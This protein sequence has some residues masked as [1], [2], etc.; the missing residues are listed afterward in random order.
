ME[1]QSFSKPTEFQVGILYSITV[2]LLVYVGS[3]VQRWN[4]N[5][6]ILITEFIL[7]LLPVLIFLFSFRFDVKN[8]LR[9]NKPT[10]WNMFLI[11]WIMLFSIPVS[12]G[13]NVLNLWIIKSVFGKIEVPAVPVGENMIGLLVSVFVIAVSAGICEEVLFRGVIMRGFERRGAVKAIVI[14]GI[15]FGFM[16][17]DFQKLIGTMLLGILIG[18]LVYR[19]NSLYCGIFA[20]FL[21]NA[22][23]TVG[24]Y[25]AARASEYLEKSGMADAK[26]PKGGDVFEIYA[27]M[28][29]IQLI[30]V[31]IAGAIMFAFSATC[32]SFLIY[33]FIK[34]SPKKEGATDIGMDRG[35]FS[36]L[37]YA[38]LLPG[39]LIVMLLYVVQGLLMKGLVA[40]ETIKQ[41]YNF[42]GLY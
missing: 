20:H 19:G 7:I 27:A 42:I 16:H 34:T 31:I 12:S 25:Y 6:G 13:I 1:K 29:Q 17:L 37:N 28:P 5:G 39:L 26:L 11:F 38:G 23:A 40:P 35:R 3:R 33:A 41:L 10:F 36:V 32:L 4:F 9:L 30:G 22:I 15:V 18:Y 21:N 2:L 8:V 14:T 24:T